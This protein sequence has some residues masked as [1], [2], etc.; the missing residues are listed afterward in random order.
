MPKC[1]N[2]KYPLDLPWEGD[3]GTKF[4][5][6]PVAE[7]DAL[8]ARVKALEEGVA[9]AKGFISGVVLASIMGI[10]PISTAEAE[11]NR[12]VDKLTALLAGPGGKVEGR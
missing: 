12:V 7:I 11:V 2:C 3:D 1:W 5:A 10:K 6:V 8:R 9:D 4:V